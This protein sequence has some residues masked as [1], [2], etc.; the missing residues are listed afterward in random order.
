MIIDKNISTYIVFSEDSILS[1]LRKISDNKSRIV[2]SVTESGKIEG[3]L[4]DGD[5]RRWIVTQKS[6]DLNQSV[7]RITNKH[8]VSFCQDDDH[9][10]I[11]AAFPTA[12]R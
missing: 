12:S 8:Y 9:E 6:I 1:A 5:F 3:V 2:F 4:T 10:K 11:R 7:S